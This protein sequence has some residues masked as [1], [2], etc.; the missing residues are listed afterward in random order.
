MIIRDRAGAVWRQL[1]MADA[2][3]LVAID[4]RLKMIRYVRKEF[5]INLIVECIAAAFKRIQKYSSNY[6]VIV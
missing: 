5:E 1:G 6:T 4:V 2:Q 3:R